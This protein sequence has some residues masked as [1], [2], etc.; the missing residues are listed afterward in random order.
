MQSEQF[1]NTISGESEVPSGP[2]M[3]TAVK[4]FKIT[5]Q[6]ARF[7][8]G[9]RESYEKADTQGKRKIL[10]TCVGECYKLRPGNAS[11]DKKLA[12]EVLLQIVNLIA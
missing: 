7:L 5:P 10:G 6:D 3:P 9:E 11:F 2:A 8:M 12:K 1:P 4:G